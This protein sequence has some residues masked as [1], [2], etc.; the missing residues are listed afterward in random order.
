VLAGG[1]TDFLELAFA[2]GAVCS[3]FIGVFFVV[4][5]FGEGLVAAFAIGF[6]AT[7]F[8]SST[9]GAETTASEA[10]IC[11]ATATGSGSGRAA[12]S[13][14]AFARASAALP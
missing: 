3:D 12:A 10:A 11:S 4:E 2:A 5:D 9:G 8:F 7:A 6:G 14:F 13:W 1:S